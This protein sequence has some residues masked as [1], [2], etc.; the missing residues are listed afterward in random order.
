VKWLL[1]LIL[2]F[3]A[4]VAVACGSEAATPRAEDQG[5]RGVVLLGPQ[6]PVETA[7]SPCP[8]VPLP[9]VTIRVLHDGEPLDVTA[10]SDE[11]G[12][13][14][15]RL[16]PGQYTLEAIV[17]PEGPGMFAKPVDVTVPAGAFVDV[18]VPVDTGIR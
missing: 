2:S 15:L 12:R 18:V 7:A 4:V 11:S 5:V 3:L 9:G 13:F 1:P 16:P 8:D 6:C 14:E 17:P 10:T